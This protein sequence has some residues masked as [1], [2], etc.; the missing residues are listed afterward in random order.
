MISRLLLA[1]AAVACSVPAAASDRTTINSL[2]A[3]HARVHGVPEA[4]VHR[5]IRRESN[6]NPRALSKGNFGLMQIRYATARGMGY[7]GSPSGL[8]D[9]NTNLTYAVPYLANA[10][11]VAGGSSDRAVALYAGG[12]YY[13][14][15]RK[16][17]LHALGTAVADPVSTG[18]IS[19]VGSTSRSS[20][21]TSANAQ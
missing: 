10:Y 14:A 9:A 3:Q 5:V 7:R 15:K 16:G 2:V 1:C 12:Y 19:T 13:E 21:F 4:L 20:A 18:S 17:L 11:K 6:Y 8:L